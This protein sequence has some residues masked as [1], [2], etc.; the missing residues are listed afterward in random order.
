MTPVDPRLQVFKNFLFLTW[1]HLGLPVPTPV[2]YDMADYL[3]HGPQRC[4]IQAFRGVGKSWIT[5]AFCVWLLYMNP[6]R[7]ILVASASKAKADEFSIFT[8]QIINEFPLVAHLKPREG[9]R[10]SNLA[11][12]VGPAGPSQAPSVKSLGINGNLTGSRADIIIPDD[13][14]NPGN[15]Y[16]QAMREK[17]STSIKEFDALLT[18]KPDSRIIYLGT[19]QSEQSVYSVLPER[20]YTMRVWPA[21]IPGAAALEGYGNTLAPFIQ[22][23]MDK[24]AK[25]GDSVDHTRFSDEDLMAREA[26]YARSGFALQF[27][28]DTTHSDRDSYPLK[29]SDM[30]IHPLDDE[31]APVKFAIAQSPEYVLQELP[32]VG[33]KGDRLYRPMFVSDNHRP[34]EGCVMAIDPSGKGSDE[35]AYA[36][37]RK[38]GGYL[39]LV[40][41]GGI[42][43]GYSEQQVLEPLAKLAK[44][45][46]VNLIQIEE[47]F[48]QGMFKSLLDPVLTRTYPV[49]TELVRHSVQKE[50][51]IVDTL[52][53]V[54]NSHRLIVDPKIIKRDAT[55]YNSYAQDVANTYGLF[56][57]L[58]RITKVRG[59]LPHDDR[60]D[61]LA[62]AVA[63]FA[64][65]MDRDT[66]LADQE[67]K[68]ADMDK[69]LADFHKGVLGYA[70]V[71]N[72][73]SGNMLSNGNGAW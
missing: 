34:Y 56:W 65:Q 62:M 12:D 28:L 15:S 63:Y 23:L 13:I 61:A 66:A 35:T 16:T 69:F 24:G 7:R 72:S 31:I 44:L 17:L 6:Q 67:A 1:Q 50:K 39:F 60:L 51:R 45:H 37:I 14:E 21:R 32:N 52:E 58:T 71:S 2:Q 57:Q 8:K 18:P 42:L 36:I 73:F 41:C 38:L 53:P 48:G 26:S 47:N 4:G 46:K 3:Q 20:G 64:E 54:L 25:E 43:G 10:D 9:Q 22:D 70:P 5:S 49:A 55:N 33:L 59:C 40:D 68:S 27:M 29:L 30:I 19:P 11:F